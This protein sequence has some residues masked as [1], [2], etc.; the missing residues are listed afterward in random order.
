MQRIFRTT[1]TLHHVTDGNGEPVKQDWKRHVMVDAKYELKVSPYQP[2]TLD[3]YGYNL[4]AFGQCVERLVL[5]NGVVLTG[6][7]RGGGFGYPGEPPKIQKIR[8]LDVEEAKIKLYPE[9]A[10]EAVTPEIDSAVFSVVSSGPLNLCGNGFSSPS[11]PFTFTKNPDRLKR[12]STEALRFHH[13][14]LEITFVGESAYW[15]KL[16][17]PQAFYEGSV[18]GIRRRG[19]G[20]LPWA[21]LN[22]VMRLLSNFLGWLNHC[23][24]PAF[25]VRAYR[26]GKLV[27]RGYDLHPN[28][29]TQRDLFSWFPSDGIKDNEGKE[30]NRAIYAD[31]LQCLLDGFAKVWQENNG[32]NGMFHIALQLLRGKEKGHPRSPPSLVYLRDTFMACAIVERMLT[33]G[34]GQS[35]RQAQIARCLKEI[36][37]ED[38]LPGIDSKDLDFVIQKHA[39]LWWAVKNSRIQEDD[40][41]GGTMSRPL[42]NVENWLLHLDDSKNSDMLL[43]LGRSVQAYLLEVSIWLAD[44]MVMKV[45]DYHG[46]YFNRLTG[47]TEKVPWEAQR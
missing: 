31:L 42:A 6:R 16:V 30:K 10:N 14:D 2:L 29:T 21:D 33:G 22:D 7:T 46:W 5:D 37:V 18:V 11:K 12:W 34:S 15:Q 47:E 17:D 20:V 44:L 41:K 13:G 8:M 38:R 3:I 23:V 27:Y 32:R 43:R 9:E 26:S 35:G 40:R 36:N 19:G 45:V 28:P 4:V 25:H 39:R 24:A 1:G